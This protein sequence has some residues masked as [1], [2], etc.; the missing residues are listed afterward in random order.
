MM[1]SCVAPNTRISASEAPGPGSYPEPDAA[2]AKL[3]KALAKRFASSSEMSK[4]NAKAKVVLKK[5]RKKP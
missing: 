5:K 4:V 1:R 2:H 3:A